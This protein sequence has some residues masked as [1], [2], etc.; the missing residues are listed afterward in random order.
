MNI[1]NKKNE[2][3][4]SWFQETVDLY[5]FLEC[6]I[7]RAVEMLRKHTEIV[8]EEELEKLKAFLS[9]SDSSSEWKKELSS[10]FRG[11][12][13]SSQRPSHYPDNWPT[14]SSGFSEESSEEFKLLQDQPFDATGVSAPIRLNFL[15]P[16]TLAS[17]SSSLEHTGDEGGFFFSRSDI[18]DIAT[19]EE[20]IWKVRKLIGDDIVLLDDNIIV[21][22]PGGHYDITHSDVLGAASIVGEEFFR[23]DSCF[24]NVWISVNGTYGDKAPLNFFPGTQQWGIAPSLLHLSLFREHRDRLEYYARLLLTLEKREFIERNHRLYLELIKK[25]YDK[26]FLQCFKRT[27]ICTEPGECIFFNSHTLHGSSPNL[28]SMSRIA[29]VFRY[30]DA[31]AKPLE[32]RFPAQVLD[33]YLKGVGKH[34]KK[35]FTPGLMTPIVQIAGNQFHPGYF[36]IQADDLRES[37]QFSSRI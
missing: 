2:A 26:E 34:R 28:S 5:S 32:F 35:D 16:T 15:T 33:G 3:V 13:Q 36:A 4:P 24:L 29:V 25:F 19:H 8:G 20:I 21:I 17:I 11:Y 31:K 6:E 23:D 30:R 9:S 12:S 1:L 10:L 7:D 27:K 14:L 18:F 37:L 22:P